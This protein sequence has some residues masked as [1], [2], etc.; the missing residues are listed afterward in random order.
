MQ[1]ITK[2]DMHLHGK[3]SSDLAFIIKTDLLARY[4]PKLLKWIDKADW[5]GPIFV[6]M[7]SIDVSDRADWEAIDRHGKIEEMAGGMQLGYC[8]PVILIQDGKKLILLD[9]HTRFLSRESID[10]KDIQAYIGTVNND[11]WKQ[12][13]RLEKNGEEGGKR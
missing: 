3:K 1:K 7:S 13:K 8:K 9:G 10:G 2:K 5:F 6:P 11:D 12:M 4:N